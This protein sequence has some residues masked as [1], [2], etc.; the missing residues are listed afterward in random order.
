MDQHQKVGQ[1]LYLG[2][3][4]FDSHSIVLEV[5]EPEGSS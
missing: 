1:P 4:D 2:T 3:H 5:S